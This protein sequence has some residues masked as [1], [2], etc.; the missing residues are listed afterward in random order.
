VLALAA[1]T[2]DPAPVAPVAPNEA[3][4]KPNDDHA[5]E[6]NIAAKGAW[7]A[8]KESSAAFT[9][10][11]QPG[12]HVNPEYPV[13]FRPE[14]SESVKFSGERVALNA[15]TKTPCADKAEDTCKAEFPF[16]A[17]PEK[18]GPAKVAGVIAFSV[19]SADKCLIEKVPVSLAIAVE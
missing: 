13:N 18:A 6:L 3:K 12:F 15:G 11:A 4:A 2:K 5:F 10:T 7:A 14:G 17:T 16:T 19:C 1:C 8:G 9:V